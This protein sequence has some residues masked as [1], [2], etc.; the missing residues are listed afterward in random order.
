MESRGTLLLKAEG[1]SK[2]YGPV[3]ALEDVNFDLYRGEVHALMGENGA[4]KSTLS[5]L[6]AGIETPTAG[7]LEFDGKPVDIP[8]PQVALKLG[9]AMVT[10]EF[11]SIPHMTVAENIFLGHKDM[12]KKGIYF[13]K[14]RAERETKELLK[15][16]DM[17][18]NI[19]PAA[20]LSTLSVAEQQ[21]VEIVKAVSYNAQMIILDEP[22][23]S[24]SN[25]EAQRLFH[26]IRDLKKK[27]VGF[28][29]VTHR[30][31]EIFEISDRITVLR[32]GRLVLSGAPMEEMTEQSLV[33]AMVGREMTNFYGEKV[34][35]TVQ[36]DEILR[37]EHLCGRGGFLKDIS[38][39]AR[40]GE[41]TGF[42]GL[43]GAGRTELM[44]AVFGADSYD[45]GEVYLD[46]VP[47]KKGS[48]RTSIKYGLSMATEDRKSEGL[49]LDLSLITNTCYAKT[50][51][52]KGW[53]LPHG[54]EKADT[55]KMVEMFRTKIGN[56]HDK[57]S[58]LSGGNQQKIVLSKWLLTNPKVL[59]VDEPTRGID[60]AAKADIYTI[61]KNL[62][63]SGMCVIVV[64]SELPEILGICDRVMVM[65]DG[66]IVK[67][68]D[69]SEASEE[70]IMGYASLGRAAEKI[71]NEETMKA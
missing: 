33:R 68:M 39:V 29:L 55:L 32:D 27:Q 18:D 31:N 47:L 1:M 63:A 57:G 22:T 9:I 30:F 20:K 38:F 15:L 66:E 10:Q 50:V 21:I 23:A 36:H 67:Q 42:A 58:S 26:V 34:E 37:V 7:K 64:S 59:I 41:I 14:H 35:N 51:Q 2:F 16:F 13:D 46:G 5:K 4:G 54:S 71:D 69:V 62:A 40:K 60:I 49:L 19:N 43:V 53:K 3:H 56:I 24:L 70:R 8:T 25:M 65:K 48:P 44:R 45:S 12:Y 28:I 6:I 61:L 17:D 52:K 11:N